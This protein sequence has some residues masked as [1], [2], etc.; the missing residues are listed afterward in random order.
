MKQQYFVVIPVSLLLFS[1]FVPATLFEATKT[2]EKPL[3]LFVGV[4]IAYAHIEAIES[5]V[6]QV[7]NYTN[8][9]VLG[10]TGITYNPGLLNEACQYIY[11]RDF[12]FLIYTEVGWYIQTPW[13]EYA[14]QTWGDKFLGVYAFDEVGGK[15]LD[16]A[17]P[18]VRE[19]ENYTDA[20]NQYV[21]QLNESLNYLTR[22]Y[23]D[24]VTY[25]LFT[26]D[27]A[28]YWFDY[29]AGYDTVFAEFGWNYSRQLNIALCRGAASVNNKDWGVIVTWTYNEPPYIESGE[30]LYEDLVLAYD[31]GAK[32]I[33]IFDSNKDYTESILR[34]EHLDALQQFWQYAQENP[35]T[36]SSVSDRVAYVL[37]EGYAYG[38]RGPADKIWGLWEADPPS[39]EISE[40]FGS[41]LREYG[42]KLDII[43]DDQL[44]LDLY[45]RKYIFSNGT[46]YVP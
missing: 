28:L 31:N 42:T 30:Q 43:Y 33:L 1:L 11:D 40:N 22:Y 5:F 21:T 7:S 16:M 4:S 34:D 24:E 45:Y 39:L 14:K 15:Q 36:T 29:K 6:D 3:E 23:T 9:I 13:L 20:S 17:H 12:S 46:I 37:P 35:R 32:Y 27:Y 41:L 8:L 19:A 25:P 38:F 2:T 44:T 10:S 26:S 18:Y